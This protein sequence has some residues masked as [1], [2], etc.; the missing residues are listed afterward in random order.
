M[1]RNPRD[2]HRLFAGVIFMKQSL[3]V[4][5]VFPEAGCPPGSIVEEVLR[6]FVR[7]ALSNAPDAPMDTPMDAARQEE[8]AR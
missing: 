1:A 8:A 7:R 2:G 3:R 4:R 6:A 5:C